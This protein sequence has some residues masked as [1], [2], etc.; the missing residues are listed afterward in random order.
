MP[1]DTAPRGDAAAKLATIT[2]DAADPAASARFWSALLDAPADPDDPTSLPSALPGG[3]GLY[4]QAVPE[5]KAA[6]NRVHLDVA[7]PDLEADVEAAKRLGARYLADGERWRVMADPEGNEF[8]A[9]GPRP[10]PPRDGR[11]VW[12]V[13]IDATDSERLAAFWGAVLGVGVSRR[14]DPYVMLDPLPGGLSLYVQSVPE[15]KQV[16]NRVHLDL[17]VPDIEQASSRAVAL[18]G[19]VLGDVETWRV[20][21]DPEGH[22]FCLVRDS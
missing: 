22:E 18:G 10:N 19:R 9:E 21:A 13:G 4:F 7:G 17:G 6:K 11:W 3:G 20:M 16:K 15:P 1:S 14:G 8:C 5:P 2:F 12:A